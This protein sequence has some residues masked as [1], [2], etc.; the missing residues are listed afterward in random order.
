MILL[1][2][3]FPM[4]IFLRNALVAVAVPFLW[5]IS[6]ALQCA[7]FVLRF[8]FSIAGWDLAWPPVVVENLKDEEYHSVRP[9]QT[10]R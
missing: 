2:I 3:R 4:L 5:A 7:L 9:D 8:T 6:L 1:G 10:E